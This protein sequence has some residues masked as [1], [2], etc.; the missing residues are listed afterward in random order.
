MAKVV[1]S[2]LPFRGLMILSVM[3]ICFFIKFY[4]VPWLVALNSTLADPQLFTISLFLIWIHVVLQDTGV[5]RLSPRS[6]GEHR[7]VDEG[8][9]LRITGGPLFTVIQRILLLFIIACIM[10]F[11][12]QVSC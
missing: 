12:K 8:F 7:P 11:L 4:P 5:A 2:T 1:I 10:R 6:V 3:T 9:L